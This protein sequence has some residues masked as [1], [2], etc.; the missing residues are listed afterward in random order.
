MA[1]K[2]L[3]LKVVSDAALTVLQEQY[4]NTLVYR[5]PSL[6]FSKHFK[7]LMF[8]LSKFINGGIEH[9]NMSCYPQLPQLMLWMF[10][11]CQTKLN[12]DSNR[13]SGSIVVISTI[14]NKSLSNVD[15]LST[16]EL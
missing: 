13:E 4:L 2:S 8:M 16:G 14:P 3:P 11:L 12:M 5:A 6:Y 7:I 10:L 15:V 1:T 9:E